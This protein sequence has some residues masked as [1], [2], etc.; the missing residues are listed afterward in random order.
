MKCVRVCY[1]Q[2]MQRVKLICHI[3]QIYQGSVGLSLYI[4]L[5]LPS[6]QV[7]G[8]TQAYTDSAEEFLP[9]SCCILLRGRARDKARDSRE[10]DICGMTQ[11]S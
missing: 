10:M 11:R 8:H 9:S 2:K 7:V 6:S 4:L 3:S 1:E 5:T